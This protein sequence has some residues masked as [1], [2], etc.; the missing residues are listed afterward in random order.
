MMALPEVMSYPNR[1]VLPKPGEISC[2]NWG[3]TCDV[4][5]PWSCHQLAEDYGI[6]IEKF[7]ELNPQLAPD[8]Q[9]IA[10]Y[11]EYCVAGCQLSPFPRATCVL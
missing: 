7:W 8:C 10:T 4:A 5:D 9:G 11:T 6:T 2:R 1:G 3:P